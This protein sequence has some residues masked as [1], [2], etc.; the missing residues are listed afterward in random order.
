MKLRYELAI[1]VLVALAVLVPGITR[2]SLVDPWETHY[3][4]V[5]RNMRHNHDLVH[6]DW[7]GTNSQGEADEGFRSKPVLTFW[8]MTAAM[9][10]VDLARDGG[11]SGEMVH[12]ARTML[13]IRLPFAYSS[14]GVVPTRAADRHAFIP[15]RARARPPAPP[16]RG[17][18]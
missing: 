16:P 9:T 11:Y 4:E 12:D 15:G 14:R 3:G 2:Y 17:R 1:V 6:M 5:A 7:P 13:A 10:A 18:W 8:L